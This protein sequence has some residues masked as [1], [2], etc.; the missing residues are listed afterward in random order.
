MRLVL[1]FVA[2]DGFTYSCDVNL[3]FVYESAEA[4]IV[5]FEREVTAAYLNQREFTFA[6]HQLNPSDF[7]AHNH[8]EESWRDAKLYLPSIWTIDEWFANEGNE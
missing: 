8:G 5:D 4:A 7:F 3:P 1:H 6:G 2:G